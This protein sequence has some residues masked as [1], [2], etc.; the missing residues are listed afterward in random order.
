[1][2]SYFGFGFFVEETWL[3][4]HHFVAL[5]GLLVIAAAIVVGVGSLVKIIRR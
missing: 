4:Y 5:G 1:M 3:L 2:K